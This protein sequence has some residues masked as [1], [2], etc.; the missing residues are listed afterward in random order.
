MEARHKVLCASGALGPPGDT[1][2]DEVLRHGPLLP[3]DG[4]EFL[5]RNSHRGR[6]DQVLPRL[7]D[8]GLRFPVVHLAKGVGARL[9]AADARAELAANL[10]FAAALG[11]RLGVLHL[12]DLPDSDRDLD[13][14]LSVYALVRNLAR[15]HGMEI[16]IESIPCTVA[17]PLR[18]LRRILDRY[19][20][21]V[22]VYDTEFLSFH[23]ELEEAL[24]DND[25]WP[26][27]RH[28]HVKDFD[29][30][31]TEPDGARRYRSPGEGRI[32]FGAV[33]A[34]IRAHAFAGSVSLE[35]GPRQ[36]A[37]G[38]DQAALHRVLA[39]LATDNWDFRPPA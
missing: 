38:P 12:W 4:I 31:F 35:V 18:N 15:E 3:V 29:G 8:S 28:I 26:A 32:D 39:T 19:P 34:A 24:E 33:S 13:G 21:A 30:R 2:V 1:G 7:R 6:L 20:D 5:V 37:G 11:A 22:L 16:G 23:G 27:V 17:T 14:R 9:P 25:L 36:R 10:R